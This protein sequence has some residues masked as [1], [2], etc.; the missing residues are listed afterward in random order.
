MSEIIITGSSGFLAK[1]TINKLRTH[2]H[3]IIPLSRQSLPDIIKVKNYLN[4]PDGDILIHFAEEANKNIV[5][6]SNEKYISSS[7]KTVEN[8]VKKFG[9]N[10]IYASSGSVYGDKGRTSFRVIDKT[11]IKD[12]YSKSKIINEQIVLNGGGTI[13]RLSN[14]YGKGMSSSNIMSDV[15]KQLSFDGPIILQNKFAIRDFVY[16]ND[17]TDFISKLIKNIVGGIFNVGSGIGM[18]VY[19]LTEIILKISNQPNREI[20]SLKKSNNKSFNVLDISKSIEMYNW[21]PKSTMPTNIKNLIKEYE[22]DQKF[23]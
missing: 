1:N 9:K 20:L 6:E 5:N 14:I 4:C 23:N 21:K 16:I 8:L 2:N 7:A 11:F 13:L 17:V 3:K 15:I 22:R 12:N 10:L 18:S 19:Q